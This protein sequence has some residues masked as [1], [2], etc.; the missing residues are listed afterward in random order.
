MPTNNA[1]TT[2]WSK[3]WRIGALCLESFLS[4]LAEL[5][6]EVVTFYT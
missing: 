4:L 1:G 6:S 5:F 3:Y 2:V